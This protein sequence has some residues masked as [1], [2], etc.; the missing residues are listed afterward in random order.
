MSGEYSV[1]WSAAGAGRK[2]EKPFI[3]AHKA[4]K[5][6]AK[7]LERGLLSFLPF[8]PYVPELCGKACA[9]EKIPLPYGPFFPIPQTCLSCRMTS[10]EILTQLKSLGSEQTRKTL[11]RHG[12]PAT[13]YGVKV[14]DLKKIQK[15]I[16]KDY[17]LSLELFDSGISDA[18]YLAGLIADE[19][20]M[21]EKDL[22]GWAEKA[23]WSMLSEYTVAWIAA[24]SD[25]GWALA[26]RWIDS[27]KESIQS[28]GWATLGSLVAIR[29]DAELDLNALRKLLGRVEKTIKNSGNRVRYAMN[30]FLISVGGYVSPLTGEA[31][32]AGK[33]IGKLTVDMN[34]TACKVPYA[35][36]LIQKMIDKGVIGKKKKMARC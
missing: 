35:P 6:Q 1:K 24:E 4:G 22:Q 7:A 19:K 13:Q 34:G 26:L 36:D 2:T 31:L 28:S 23:S 10:A 5:Q 20:R 11:M 18:Q 17:S 21:T 15:K 14:E 25:H 12:A 30:G 32:E 33:R 8:L 27:E 16:K 9:L 3:L 29:P